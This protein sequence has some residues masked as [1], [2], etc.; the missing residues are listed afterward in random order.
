MSQRWLA[1][2]CLPLQGPEVAPSH[3]LHSQ[4]ELLIS[5]VALPQ[6]PRSGFCLCTRESCSVGA[7]STTGDVSGSRGPA[8]MPSCVAGNEFTL[9]SVLPIPAGLTGRRRCCRL[10][11]HTLVPLIPDKNPARGAANTT[12]PLFLAWKASKLVLWGV[13]R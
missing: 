1:G 13:G 5:V 9:Y 8:L 12:R 2:S 3:Q 10:Q 7:P 4:D 6:L 11:L